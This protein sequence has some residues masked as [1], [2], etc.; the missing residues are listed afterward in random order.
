MSSDVSL[1]VCVTLTTEEVSLSLDEVGGE[2]LGSVTV[3]EGEGGGEG[4]DGDTPEGGLSNDSSPSWLGTSNS[5]GEEGAGEQVLELG[6]LSVGGGDVGKED[7]LDDASTS[8]HGGD[9]SVVEGP[10]VD[11]GG[12]S[13]EHESLSVRDDLGSVK[14][15]LEVVDKLLLVALEGLSGRS[16]EDLGSSNSLLLEGR[17]ASG[18]DG[19]TDKGDGHALVE[20][21]NGGPLSGSLLSSSVEDLLDHGDT[22]SVVELEDVSGDLDQERVE[23]ALLPL[24][25]SR[26]L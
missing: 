15:L 16:G 23:D 25:I 3:E 22:V 13:H 14:G 24:R 8:P 10:A 6:V 5:L 26:E 17:E 9:T 2:G 21:V 11:L 1:Q 12:L 18:K 7:R 19:L 20:G 4:R